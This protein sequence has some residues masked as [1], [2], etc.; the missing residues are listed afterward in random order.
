MASV[1]ACRESN[2][3]RGNGRLVRDF[4][5]QAKHTRGT[6]DPSLLQA[7]RPCVEYDISAQKWF[8]FLVH[9]ISSMAAAA[10]AAEVPH[11]LPSSG[12]PSC[13]RNLV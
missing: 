13:V 10:L 4:L 8:I 6:V 2:V 3:D 1:K 12:T 11:S 9:C 7:D 5:S